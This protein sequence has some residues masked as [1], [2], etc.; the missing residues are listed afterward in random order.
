MANQ[1]YMEGGYGLVAQFPNP[2][3]APRNPTPNDRTNPN[4]QPY[5]PF[6]GWRNT[7]TTTMF[8][9]Q[10]QGVWV[11]IAESGE[12][13][14]TS[15][16]GNSGGAVGPNAGNV[17]IVGSDTIDIVG[18][19]GTNTLT[20]SAGA[21][22]FPITP[23][24]VGPSGGYSTIQSAITAIGAA[25]GLIYLQPGTFTENLTFVAGSG[26]TI[27]SLS[28]D[29]V[30]IVGIHTPQTSGFLH[31]LGVQMSSATHILSSGAA[32]S[33]QI[34][35]ESC[36]VSCTNGFTFNLTAWTGLLQS[37]HCV[38]TG[39][40]NGFC[41]NAGG[42]TL[43]ISDSSVGVGVGQ[44]MITSGPV[45]IGAVVQ[46]GVGA[47]WSAGSGSIINGSQI[48]FLRTLTLNGTS[49]ADLDTCLWETGA[50]E[51][52]TMASSG[53][54]NISNSTFNSSEPTVITGAG[55]G[56][57]TLTD[58]AF[59]NGKNISGSLTLANGISRGGSY[60]TQYTVGPAPDAQFRTIQA[61]VTA[62]G[63][64]PAVLYLQPGSYAENVTFVNACNLDI[65]SLNPYAATISGIHVPPATGTLTFT[66][67]TLTSATHI[68]N[69]AVAGTAQLTMDTCQA[70]CTDGFSFNVTNWV[71]A[72]QT[73]HSVHGG[74][75]NG[76]IN[77]STGSSP[78]F[79]SDS[80]IGAGTTLTLQPGSGTVS[81]EQTDIINPF[82]TGSGAT[83]TCFNCSFQNT[84]SIGTAT[85]Q[86]FYNSYFATGANAGIDF[87]VSSATIGIFNSSINSSAN[88]C[89]IGTAGTLVAGGLIF[90]NNSIISASIT[91][92]STS[93][94]LIGGVQFFSGTGAPGGIAPKGSLYM[95]LDGSGIANRAYINTNGS[96]AWTNLVTAG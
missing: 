21:S 50:A 33:T 62:I 16:T 87:Q 22:G 68:L 79:V 37:F 13:P 70:S 53:T 20:I 90:V 74:T 57:V 48:Q 5:P 44:T 75:N 60:L 55:A 95:R 65:V 8:L 49:T 69:S 34:T 28:T 83:V 71:G 54:V 86:N 88:P 24:V 91:L 61:A 56:I 47:Q 78:F 72:I 3:E 77:N 76:V 9:Y 4:G 2:I 93:K 11:E 23:F 40:S 36:V 41:N 19:P 18:N 94:N 64:T 81:L 58:C 84:V 15:V 31:F 39:T 67:L 42:S 96:T 63:T 27:A 51:C 89:I 30:S 25:T 46:G 6:Q 1:V 73:F 59:V 32:G 43:N 85:T 7:L 82:F 45:N 26:V 10:G 35:F 38:H 14:I 52:I 66:A 80:T 29:T 12:G 92:T 17:N